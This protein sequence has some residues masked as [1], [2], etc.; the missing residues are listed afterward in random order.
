MTR[1]N[2]TKDSIETAYSFLPHQ[3]YI[4]AAAMQLNRM[5]YHMTIMN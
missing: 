1:K 3:L 2:E 5:D 4:F